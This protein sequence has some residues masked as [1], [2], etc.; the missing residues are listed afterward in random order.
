MIAVVKN[1]GVVFQS[2]I[3]QFLELRP[4]LCVHLGDLVMVLGPIL[5]HLRMIGVIGGDTHFGRIVDLRVRAF[6]D[7][8][9]VTGREVEDS[10]ERLIL[11]GTVSPMPFPSTFIPYLTFLAEVVIFFGVVRAVVAEL[12][13]VRGIHL[14]LGWQAGHASHVLGTG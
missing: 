6:A 7:S 4:D 10:E 5:A 11:V 9:F 12:T 8:A 1:D 13:Q 2:G 3:L 14:V